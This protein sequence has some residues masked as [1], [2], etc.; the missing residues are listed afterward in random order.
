VA[1]HAGDGGWGNRLEDWLV[2]RGGDLRAVCRGD[3]LL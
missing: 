3:A 2:E 1:G